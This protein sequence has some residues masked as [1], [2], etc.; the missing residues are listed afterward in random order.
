MV[1]EKA[2]KKVGA[3]SVLVVGMSG[4]GVEIAKNIVLAGVK[5]VT[6]LDNQAVSV[7]DLG[8]NF[9]L[10]ENMVGT[11]R[12]SA[13]STALQ[14]L[15]GYV[16]VSVEEGKLSEEMVAAHSIVIMVDSH[17][18]TLLKVSDWARTGQ[19]RI[20]WRVG[21]TTT[22]TQAFLRCRQSSLPLERWEPSCTHSMTS[23]R[24]LLFT[25]ATAKR[26]DLVWS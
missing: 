10:N 1:G 4:L 16:S 2:Q 9:F 6:L 15:N 17:K 11:S 24:P 3:A 7:Y 20:V 12:A 8:T 22:D 13:S 26:R 14:E 19:V 18:D 25:T 21:S 23:A 5:S